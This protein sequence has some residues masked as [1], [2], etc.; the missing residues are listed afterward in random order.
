M[1]YSILN[2]EPEPLE[3][4]LP[5]VPAEL[6]HIV[7][8]ALEK[9]PAD[10]YQSAED[11]AIDLRRVKKDTGRISRAGIPA[12]PSGLSA[13]STSQRP[14][15]GRHPSAL[16]IG[17]ALA[18]G[19]VVIVLGWMALFREQGI[20]GGSEVVE[21]QKIVVLPFQN[22]GDPEMEYFAD[23]MTEEITSRLASLSRLGVIGRSSAIQYK[24]TTKPLKEIGAELGVSY[25][26]EGTVRWET[27]PDG[28]TRVRI[29]PQLIRV[30][31]ATQVWSQP[32]EAVLSG[33]FSV[34]SE[35]ASKVVDAMGIQLVGAEQRSMETVRAKNPEAYDLYLRGAGYNDR[36]YDRG[37]WSIAVDLLEKAVAL[38]PEF[39]QAYARLSR[40]H[41]D[42][43]WFH[44]DRSEER[45]KKSIE[46]AQKAIETDP[47]LADGYEAMGWYYYH[48]LLDYDRALAQFDEALRRR[49]QEPGAMYGMAAVYRRQGKFAQALE[50]F[51]KAAA[52]D[53]R[54]PTILFNTGETH[55]LMRNYPAAIGY[56]DRAIVLSPDWRAPYQLKIDAIIRDA[57]DIG[58]AKQVLED[59][60]RKN[61]SGM[62]S[63]ALLLASLERNYAHALEI[64]RD[65]PESGSDSQFRFIPRVLWRADIYRSMGRSREAA[66]LYD[67]ARIE[68]QHALG[69]APEDPRLHA[70]LGRALA[71]LGRTEEALQHAKRAVEILP[72]SREAY[73]GAYLA[74]SQAQTQAMVGKQDE[75]V[76]TLKALLAVPSQLSTALLR[77]DPAWDELRGHPGFQALLNVRHE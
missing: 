72:M 12:A 64:L 21:R 69:D 59:A 36:G 58:K 1:M 32:Y 65:D 37:D 50:R 55:L 74:E 38:D 48:G 51:E 17:G 9:D 70:A 23:G 33:V 42:F 62:G 30:G 11:M 15:R 43:Y 27:S 10:R 45:L 28:E 60:R 35:I 75:A 34:Q 31:D 24:K 13:R 61:V 39:A 14:I 3:E 73:R 52:L 46:A 18:L 47:L 5:D 26:L 22:L 8:K 67:S 53:P 7:R 44:F 19:I 4:V 6:V 57:G 40:L 77:L 63:T 56:F 2:E 20:V 76:A 16:K 54:D 68:L 29:T 71:G 49:P 41:S 25:V 66:A